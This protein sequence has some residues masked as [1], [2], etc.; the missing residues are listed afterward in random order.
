MPDPMFAI[1]RIEARNIGPITHKAL[2]AMLAPISIINWPQNTGKTTLMFDV[3]MW[4]LFGKTRNTL[5]DMYHKGAAEP[6]EG[7]VTFLGAGGETYTMIRTWSPGGTTSGSLFRILADGERETLASTSEAGTGISD[8]EAAL[9]CILGPLTA[10]IARLTVFAEQGATHLLC[11]NEPSKVRAAFATLTGYDEFPEWGKLARAKLRELKAQIDGYKATLP[12]T[13]TDKERLERMEQLAALDTQR[14]SLQRDIA[15][16]DASLLPYQKRAELRA[17]KE[18]RQN[19]LGKHREGLVERLEQMRAQI[20]SVPDEDPADTVDLAALKATYDA[21][22]ARVMA[23]S[24]GNESNEWTDPTTIE[25]IQ[26]DVDHYAATIS[27]C[28]REIGS[29]PKADNCDG[30]HFFQKIQQSLDEAKARLKDSEKELADFKKKQKKVQASAEAREQHNAVVN[31]AFT[32]AAEAYSTAEEAVKKRKEALKLRAKNE[33]LVEE[34]QAQVDSIPV[35]DPAQEVSD[36]DQPSP[37]MLE[38]RSAKVEELNRIENQ[39][40]AYR[41]G[42]KIDDTNRAS[43]KVIEG[44]IAALEKQA[45]TAKVVMDTCTKIAAM[46]IDEMAPEIE[47][48]A[49]DILAASGLPRIS[50]ITQEQSGKSVKETFEIQFHLPE[51]SLPVSSLGGG[52]QYLIGLALRVAFIVAV[53]REAEINAKTVFIQEGTGALDKERRAKFPEVLKAMRKAIGGNLVL[54]THQDDIMPPEGGKVIT[55]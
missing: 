29:I 20:A 32:Q 26:D 39:F 47:R 4:V 13:L 17:E 40:T 5:Q 36:D 15:L 3:P 19:D 53:C 50:V 55:A 45:A 2:D 41:N 9:A 31:E 7:H 6:M 51:G 49:S 10:E 28:E 34:L 14:G 22:L 38:M 8:V 27:E 43:R 54:S 1:K 23:L 46:V 44:Y 16:L 18:K 21:A 48:V 30:C 24:T 37:E 52:Y 11:S 33:V 42:L 12:L 35:V 25:T